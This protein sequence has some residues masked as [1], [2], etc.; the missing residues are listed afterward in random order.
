MK[1]ITKNT[2]ITKLFLYLVIITLYIYKISFINL[3]YKLK[4]R[5]NQYR[6]KNL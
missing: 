6:L 3:G 5:G 1:A 4:V 2:N